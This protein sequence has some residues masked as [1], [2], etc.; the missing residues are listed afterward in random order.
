MKL[1]PV[2]LGAVCLIIAAAALWLARTPR[3]RLNVCQIAF[4][5]LCLL[6]CLKPRNPDGG[7]P[8]TGDIR[9][10]WLG[11][12]A[13]AV[14]WSTT[15]GVSFVS[16]D[17]SHLYVA[18]Q[19]L[20]QLWMLTRYGQDHTFLRPVGFA[21][22]FLDYRLF[23]LQ[24]LGYHAVNIAIHLLVIYGVYLL[25]RELGVTSGAAAVTA[26]IYAIMP[27]HAEV[28]AWLG[29]RFD[30]LATGFLLFSV[31]LLLRSGGK[32]FTKGF[33]AA[34]LLYCLSSLA[35][36]SGLILPALALAIRLTL[37]R[38]VEN[39]KIVVL[40]IAGAALVAGRSLILGGIGGY[41]GATHV[42]I[43]TV[44]GFLVRGPVQALIGRNWLQPPNALSIAIGAAT[45]ACL[46]LL[47]AQARLDRPGAT[48]IVAG[49]LWLLLAMAPAHLLLMI[50]PD[51]T[52][53]RVL[54]LPSVGIAL[55]LGQLIQAT[56]NRLARQVLYSGLLLIY[57]VGTLS[58]IAAW[59]HTSALTQAM[60]SS[61]PRL[62][63]DPP[64]NAWFVLSG[65][66]ATVRGVFF[67]KVAVNDAI[68]L[69][70]R[71]DDI[72]AARDTDVPAGKQL[73]AGPRIDLVWDPGTEMLVK[74]PAR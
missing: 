8:A 58:N 39:A 13:G 63:P 51:L 21:S 66:P 7:T 60:I 33:L 57:S 22:I 68:R 24:P 25:A 31:V 52:N 14:V 5:L 26:G 49:W 62:E 72:A 9:W 38:D 11:V 23:G 50:G 34:V 35:K 17:F 1:P 44:L 71:R 29:A 55:I 40:F 43:S 30:L 15:L 65:V 19:G 36:E 74:N 69:V 59:V 48:M 4:L 10:P 42:G 64:Q 3:A 16:D 54:Y 12:A 45:I 20:S 67:M 27:V 53:S 70:Y 28:V 46:I 18:R 47:V 61:I 73:A 2:L 6:I 32:G 37:R 56:P 41:P